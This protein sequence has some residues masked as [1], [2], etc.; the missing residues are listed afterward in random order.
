MN[1][2]VVLSAVLVIA[3]ASA[4]FMSSQLAPITGVSE[5]TSLVSSTGVP[6]TTR[7]PTTGIP[8]NVRQQQ[9]SL[10]L[11]IPPVTVRVTFMLPPTTLMVTTTTTSSV[12]TTTVSLTTRCRAPSST[13][14]PSS[15]LH[16]RCLPH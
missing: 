8:T 9:G 3:A 2:K 1:Y 15:T 14:H 11:V 6:L 4:V 10:R 12:V 16:P 7:S 13:V 5:T